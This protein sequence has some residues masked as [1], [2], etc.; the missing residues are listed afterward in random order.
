MIG[1]ET[2]RWLVMP[3][4]RAE[5]ELFGGVLYHLDGPGEV[6]H[7][8]AL[9]EVPQ[10]KAVQWVP[11]AG[12][13]RPT[14]GHWLPLLKRIQSA[15]KALQIYARAREIELYIEHLRPEGLMLHFG[16]TDMDLSEDECTAL[17]KR[18][19]RWA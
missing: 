14:S 7:L 5:A 6:Q 8:D 18:I 11:I 16:F 3:Q 13:T 12:S 1:P 9:L 4:M 17:M 15:G 10:I 19:E 2:F